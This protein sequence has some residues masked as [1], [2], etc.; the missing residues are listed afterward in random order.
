VIDDI[1]EVA[2]AE[3]GD[4]RSALHWLERSGEAERA[5]SPGRDAGASVVAL[6][7][8]DNN[9]CG[10]TSTLRGTTPYTVRL[11]AIYSSCLSNADLALQFENRA[12]IE[13]TDGQRTLPVERKVASRPERAGGYRLAHCDSRERCVVRRAHDDDRLG[14]VVPAT[15]RRS[16]TEETAPVPSLPALTNIAYGRLHLAPTAERPVE[17]V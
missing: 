17:E 12:E 16:S 10:V 9:Q 3:T 11:H 5:G 4:L 7:T 15:P 1:E 6:I 8:E 2:Y 13:R 14:D